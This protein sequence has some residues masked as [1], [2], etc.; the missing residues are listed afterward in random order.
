MMKRVEK[1]SEPDEEILIA[2]Y[3]QLDFILR[4]RYDRTVKN[5]RAVFS[6][7]ELHF[8]LYETMHEETELQ[9]LSDFLG[10]NIDRAKIHERY[11]VSP[12][13]QS[14]SPEAKILVRQFYSEVYDFCRKEFPE[15]RSHWS[16]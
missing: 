1:I 6:E 8:G 12:K 13:F 10:I 2:R 14:V 7:T 9:R 15:A 16:I 4:T 11:N 5:L 3:S